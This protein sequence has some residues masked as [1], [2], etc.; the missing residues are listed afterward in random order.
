MAIAITAVQDL[1][2]GLKTS[3]A[4]GTGDVNSSRNSTSQASGDTVTISTEGLRKSQAMTTRAG[5]SQAGENV[6]ENEQLIER[7][8]KQIEQ[9]RKEIEQIEAGNLPDEEKKEKLQMKRQML[10]MMEA[11]LSE[12]QTQALKQSGTSKYGGTRAQGFASSLT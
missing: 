9:L 8:Q 7:L 2:Q 10:S 11:Q 1:A 3:A 6:P 4:A 12:A 5:D